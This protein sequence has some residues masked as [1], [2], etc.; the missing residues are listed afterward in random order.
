MV[1]ERKLTKKELKALR[2]LEREQKEMALSES[3]SG[4][5]KWFIMGIIA[6][7]FIGFFGYM[8]YVSKQQKAEHAAKARE[9]VSVGGTVR[10]DKAAKITL[11]EYGDMQCPSCQAAQPVVN[12][13]LA[14]RKDVKLVFKHFPISS[15][16]PNAMAGATAV[17]AAGK[18]GKFFEMMDLM[19]KNQTEW[20]DLPNPESKYEE[21]ASQLKLDVAK[22]KT[23]LKDKSI[24]D[25]IEKERNEGVAIGVSGTPTFFVNGQ[26]ID[27]PS[28]A[29]QLNDEI[30][31]VAGKK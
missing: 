9:L 19:Y 28:S 14:K 15:L 20:R 22:F 6:I 25:K 12:E 16:H 4:S 3:S 24:Q 13:A 26:Q 11:V 17:E 27:N 23:D 10:G 29:N 30:N 8:V 18:Q 7:L 5:K 21:Y 1:E 2:R 31:A